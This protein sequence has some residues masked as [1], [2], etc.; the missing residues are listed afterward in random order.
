MSNA[1]RK[2]KREVNAVR[3]SENGSRKER[4]KMESKAGS[5]E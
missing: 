1:W 2:G 5:S 4:K 3:I